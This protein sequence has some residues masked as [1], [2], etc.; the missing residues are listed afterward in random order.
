MASMF[1]TATRVAIEEI[2]VKHAKE[3]KFGYILTKQS[4]AELVNDFFDLLQTSRNLKSAGDRFINA[5]AGGAPGAGARS[6]T[7]SRREP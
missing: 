2:I 1:E 4:V 7:P 6:R 3:G 5:A